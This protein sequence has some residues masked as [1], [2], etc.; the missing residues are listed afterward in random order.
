[1]S[2][3]IFSAAA[4]WVSLSAADSVDSGASE[5]S[6]RFSKDR[7]QVPNDS[8]P[9]DNAGVAAVKSFNSYAPTEKHNWLPIWIK[10]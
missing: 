1:M 10:I 2:F 5:A 3:S 7:S 9:T 6:V 8:E 4:V